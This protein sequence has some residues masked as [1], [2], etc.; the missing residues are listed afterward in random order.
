[1]GFTSSAGR[2]A[3]ISFSKL[4]SSSAA[5]SS[6]TPTITAPMA[7]WKL[8]LRRASGALS[9]RPP[10]ISA[11][12]TSALP[13]LYASATAS[14]PA[15]KSCAA[16]TVITPAR[17]GPAQGAYTNPRLAPSR[18]PEAKPSPPARTGVRGP[19]RWSH[20]SIRAAAT[21]TSSATPVA[22]STTMASVRNRSSGTPSA[23]SR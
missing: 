19:I 9:R 20:A 16:D 7:R 14:R 18:S 13:A 12:S 6:A 17:I 11:Y 2:W 21:G 22:P 4:M 8:P 1:V 3:A 5:I 15:V 10:S 23:D